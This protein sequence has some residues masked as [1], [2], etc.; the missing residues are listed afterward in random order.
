MLTLFNWNIDRCW[1][2][3]MKVNYFVSMGAV[4]GRPP[5]PVATGS[6]LKTTASLKK[7]TQISPGDKAKPGT[8]S[9]KGPEKSMTKNSI[10]N[11]PPRGSGDIVKLSNKFSSL[12]EMAME[13]GGASSI[14]PHKTKNK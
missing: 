13:L 8:A 6:L 1:F 5:S 11:R 10:S 9:S 4:G 12:D 3:V 14:S 2:N 7:P